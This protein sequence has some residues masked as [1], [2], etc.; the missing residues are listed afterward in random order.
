[1]SYKVRDEEDARNVYAYLFSL[2]A[3]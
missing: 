1:M 2:S 3:E